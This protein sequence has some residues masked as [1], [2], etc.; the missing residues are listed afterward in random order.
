MRGAKF[1]DGVG[2]CMN[3]EIIIALVVFVAASAST[4]GPNN[5]M[6]MASGANFG[7]RR[8]V[9][10]FFGIM[11]G[12]FIM[13]LL[14][15]MG[16]MQVFA[17]FPLV[18]VTLKTLSILYLLF[19]AW[20]IAVA[21][22]L[23]DDADSDTKPIGKPITFL[24]AVLFQWVNPKAWAVILTAI[25]AYTPPTHPPISVFIV[26]MTFA[27]VHFFAGSMWILIGTQLRRLLTEPVK[28]RIFNC[29]VAVLLVASVIPVFFIQ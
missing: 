9:P 24:Q 10:H 13:V 11:F 12:V 18:Y 15:G 21:A 1:A 29:G 5:F 19:L 6:L 28:L 7:V 26:A 25:S 4:P 3:Y 2:G 20:K 23:R 27:L 16:L 22:P 8:S 17:R 14:V